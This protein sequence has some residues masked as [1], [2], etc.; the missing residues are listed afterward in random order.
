MDI[1]EKVNKVQNLFNQQKNILSELNIKN[2]I[3]S[4]IKIRQ[5]E[6]QKELIKAIPVSKINT[7]LLRKTR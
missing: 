4:A 2:Y 7:T 1:Q 3:D 5:L 6:F